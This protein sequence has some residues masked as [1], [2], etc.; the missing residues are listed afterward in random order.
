M[1]SSKASKHF[2]HLEMGCPSLPQ[3][4]QVSLDFFLVFEVD[5]VDFKE[6]LPLGGLAWGLGLDFGVC[7]FDFSFFLDFPLEFWATNAWM[8]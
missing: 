8:E 5:S 3:K 6:Y 1:A 4:L 2:W 7:F